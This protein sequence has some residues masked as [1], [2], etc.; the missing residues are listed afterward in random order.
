MVSQDT[1]TTRTPNK[2]SLSLG[3]LSDNPQNNIQFGCQRQSKEPS[4]KSQKDCHLTLSLTSENDHTNQET[5]AKHELSI[6]QHENFMASGVLLFSN[7]SGC[8]VKRERDDSYEEIEHPPNDGDHHKMGTRKKLRLTKEQSALLE[9]SFRVHNTLSPNQK[10]ELAERLKLRPRQ[11]EVWFQNRRAR[12]KLKQTEV[13]CEFLKK[14]CE[15]LTIENQKLYRELEELRAADNKLQPHHQAMYMQLLP[16]ATAT[17]SLC[18]SC[19]KTAAAYQ[20]APMT[21]ISFA[22]SARP[23]DVMIA[24]PPHRGLV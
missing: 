14:C 19:E 4:L 21:T 23:P 10:L 7:N 2:L 18:S 16:P 20:K 12:T 13:D 5:F 6:N 17:L 9:G 11:V 22:V 3:F 15:T 1:T 8:V 24:S